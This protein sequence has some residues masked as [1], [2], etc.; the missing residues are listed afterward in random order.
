M[1]IGVAGIGGKSSGSVS[2]YVESE[3]MVYNC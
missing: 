2:S 1:D 3:I